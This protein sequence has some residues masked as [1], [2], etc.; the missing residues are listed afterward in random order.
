M[1]K[2]IASILALSMLAAMSATAFAAEIDQDDN[3]NSEAVITT[4]ILPTYTVSIPGNTDVK[5]KNTET[6][7]GSIKVIAA[8]IDPDMQI[9]VSLRTDGKLDNQT[10]STKTIPYT[11]NDVDGEFTSAVYL[12]AGDQTDLTI[13]I[14][15]ADWNAAYAGSYS[16]TVTFTV[17][18][19]EIN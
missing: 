8:Q 4:N 13:N 14:T 9:R 12:K 18:Y 1:K 11:V 10:D 17:S 16:D 7:F 3:P 5:F 2:M 6:D 19:E 15:Q